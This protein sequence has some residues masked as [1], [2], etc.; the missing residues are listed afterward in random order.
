MSDENKTSI[1]LLST[2][3]NVISCHTSMVGIDKN[4]KEKVAGD[5]MR[6][7]VPMMSDPSL[8]WGRGMPMS[9]HFAMPACA[10][11]S[12]AMPIGAMCDSG[13]PPPMPM[14]MKACPPRVSIL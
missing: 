2:A 6:R 13:P 14:R 8:Q 10:M 7:N 11:Y 3:A 1:V 9:G 5:L 12:C 4:R